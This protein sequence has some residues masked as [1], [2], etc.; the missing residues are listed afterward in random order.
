MIVLRC[1]RKLLKRLHATPLDISPPSTTLLGD[2]YANVL[3]VYRRPLILAVSERT[4]LPILVPARDLSSLGERLGAA[5]AEILLALGIPE[6]AAREEQRQMLPIVFARTDSRQILGTMNDFDRMLEPRPG[7]TLV[8]AA[9]E[10]AEAPCSPIGMESP[11]RATVS[12][13][14]SAR[15]GDRSNPGP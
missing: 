4:L 14:A 7:Q 2:W 8:S 10:L 6:P 15:R 12:L 13:F 11:D 1:T 9:L 3:F 5:L